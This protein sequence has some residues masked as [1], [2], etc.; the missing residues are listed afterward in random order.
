MT[1]EE[2]IDHYDYLLDKEDTKLI[3]EKAISQL[4]HTGRELL[5]DLLKEEDVDILKHLRSEYTDVI[6]FDIFT[7]ITDVEEQINE[8]ITIH[9]NDPIFENVAIYKIVK[10]LAGE[11]CKQLGQGYQ[12]GMYSQDPDEFA[13]NHD[14]IT[15]FIYIGE[16]FISF[17]LQIVDSY[18]HNFEM[19]KLID[20][21]LFIH[22]PKIGCGFNLNAIKKELNDFVLNIIHLIKQKFN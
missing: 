9:I 15:A 7:D 3:C 1:L 16:G 13:A 17:R 22:Y 18:E 2:F 5:C 8:N 20:D 6:L 4:S 11:G 14:R 19:D 12:I 10:Y 21:S